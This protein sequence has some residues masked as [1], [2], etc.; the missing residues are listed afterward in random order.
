MNNPWIIA[1][2]TIHDVLV[3][4]MIIALAGSL[5]LNA[6]LT[7]RNKELTGQLNSRTI[8]INLPNNTMKTW[9]IQVQPKD[10]RDE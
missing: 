3:F 5:A 2:K 8:T 9:Y 4:I 1:D 10:Y 6:N 7:R